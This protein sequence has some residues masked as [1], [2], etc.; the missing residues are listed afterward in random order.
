MS[1]MGFMGFFEKAENRLIAAQYAIRNT[2]FGGKNNVVRVELDPSTEKVK[3]ILNATGRSFD[4]VEEAFTEASRMMLT[5]FSTVRPVSGSI[6]ALGKLGASGSLETRNPTQVAAVGEILQRIQQNIRASV[7]DPAA[8]A[9]LEKMGFSREVL[10]KEELSLNLATIKNQKSIKPIDFLEGLRKKGQPFL[11][12]MDKDGATLM[13]FKLGEKVLSEAESYMLLAAAGNP[14]LDP[15]KVT[16]LL[17]KGEGLDTFMTKLGKRIRAFVGDR[18]LTMTLSDISSIDPKTGIPKSPKSLVIDEGLDFLKKSLGM[19]KDSIKQKAI[20]NV[21]AEE[22]IRASFERQGI[23]DLAFLKDKSVMD[24]VASSEN[25]NELIEKMET[26][27]GK[28]SNNF[29]AFKQYMKDA[30]QEIDGLAVF[31]RKYF[32]NALEKMRSNITQ[33]ESDITS[34]TLSPIQR[35]NAQTALLELKQQ[36]EMISRAENYYQ[37]TGRG[38]TGEGAIKVAYDIR[39]M[40][41]EF[42]EY[43]Q[44]IG[45]SGLKNEL[46]FIADGEDFIQMSGFGI[47]SSKV[48]ADPVTAAFHPELYTTEADLENIGK[49]SAQIMQDF[50][51]AVE[52]NTLPEKVKNMLSRTLLEDNSDLPASV[53]MSKERNREFVR[54]IFELHQSGVGPKNSPEMMNLLHNVFATEAFR[55]QTKGNVERYLPVMPD[56][57]RFA[58]ASETTEAL[59]SKE[60]LSKPLNNIERIALSTTENAELMKFRVSG[61]KL[62]FGAGQI[63]EFFESLGGF[64]LD[65]KGIIKLETFKDSSNRRR[66]AFALTRQPS[67]IEEVIYASAR[68]NDAETIRNIFGENKQFMNFLEKA[69]G[70]AAR[71]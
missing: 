25:N 71:R 59:G 24:I 66:L 67:G 53:R 19:D 61:H 37:V 32:N 58:L 1:S 64:D 4:T 55:I 39:Y 6:T 16:S 22:I 35:Q 38:F 57:G 45:R 63:P 3:F 50:Q 36:Y 23:T 17:Q 56:A 60:K 41:K 47:P 40:D 65:D 42:D 44:I 9:A 52:T 31:N 69:S 46:G 18:D 11:P 48:Y 26:L 13:Q 14:I 12:I 5:Q 7:K 10:E 43:Y 20:R 49:Y 15:D 2:A 27:L 51:E 62:L 8:L 28:D 29:K 30:E 54:R 68:L 33:L 70:E 21:D 34:K